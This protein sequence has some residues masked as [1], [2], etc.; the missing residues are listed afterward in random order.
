MSMAHIDTKNLAKYNEAAERIDTVNL[1]RR[2]SKGVYSVS[3]ILAW[4]GYAAI[5]AIV[6]MV[7]IDVCGRYFF[8]TPLRG[9]FELVEQIMICL[10][11]FSIMY[12]AAKRGHVV[13]DVILTRFSKLNQTILNSIFSLVGFGA[14]IVMGYYVYQYGLRQLKPYPQTT[15]L[16]GV[17]TSPF[18]FALAAA[19][20]LCSLIFL[21]QLFDFWAGEGGDKEKGA[22]GI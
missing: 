10:G 19:M 18:H 14:S 20:V 7:F 17:Y 8:N 6:L 22:S 13:V 15:D 9:S 5:I 4:V 1:I 3:D 12:S 11:G 21:I 2:M 16:L